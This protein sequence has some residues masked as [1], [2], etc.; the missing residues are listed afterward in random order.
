VY[1]PAGTLRHSADG[2]MRDLRPADWVRTPRES[3]HGCS[4]PHRET[5]RALIVLTTDI[6][7]QYSRDVADVVNSGGPPNR[8]RLL[9]VTARYGPDAQR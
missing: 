9:A 2:E 7:P 6:G 8:T 4:S 3:V 1:V 5:A